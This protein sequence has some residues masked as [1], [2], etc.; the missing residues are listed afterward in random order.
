[1]ISAWVFLEENEE[2]GISLS[3][4]TDSEFSTGIPIHWTIRY[5]SEYPNGTFQLG[6][7]KIGS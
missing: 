5:R 1:L 6:L 7:P 3:V 2:S 4:C